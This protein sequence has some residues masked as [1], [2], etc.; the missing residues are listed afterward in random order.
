MPEKEFKLYSN[1]FFIDF[2]IYEKETDEKAIVDLIE[3]YEYKKFKKCKNTYFIAT[4]DTKDIFLSKFTNFFNTN[5]EYLIIPIQQPIACK[6]LDKDK[7]WFVNY[8]NGR[9]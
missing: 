2:T 8:I 6:L 7:N 9:I 5:D 3:S 4:D 1:S